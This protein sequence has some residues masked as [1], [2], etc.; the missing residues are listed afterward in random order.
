[1]SFKLKKFGWR[2]VAVFSL[3]ISTYP[4]LYLVKG[5]KVGLLLSKS[6]EIL[7]DSTWTIGFY[8][9]IIFGGIALA[10]GWIQFNEKWR[11]RKIDL[12]RKIGKIY[13]ICVLISGICGVYIG[14][15]ATGGIISSV[16]FMALGVTWLSTTI[17]SFIAIKNGNI[18]RHQ[19]LMTYSYAA[20]FAAVTLR[21]WLPLLIVTIGEF[22][23]A[24]R[25]VAYLCWIP[26]IIVAYFIVRRIKIIKPKLKMEVI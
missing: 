5:K 14:Y 21:I 23:P 10:I 9:H 6:A 22:I 13:I 24:Y 16:G 20:C 1:M 18:Y 26:N 11:N 15:F 7:S 25:T 2:T 12:H 3:L 17:G 4:I 19:V 8:G